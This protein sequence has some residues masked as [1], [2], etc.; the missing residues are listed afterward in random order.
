MA[1]R[2]VKDYFQ[3]TEEQYLEM[4]EDAE[5]LQKLLDEGKIAEEFVKSYEDK[6]LTIKQ[7]YERLAYIMYLFTIP[8][9][10]KKRKKFTKQSSNNRIETY[11]NKNNA[12]VS[13]VT[14][15]NCDILTNL[16]KMI[17]KEECEK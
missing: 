13:K 11:L 10:E 8:N 7:N 2:H 17:T 5:E 15:E 3:K 1:L 16:K 4:K 14:L 9:R 6:L 12:S